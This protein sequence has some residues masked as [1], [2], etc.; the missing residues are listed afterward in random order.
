MKRET[1]SLLTEHLG[2]DQVVSD[3]AL[4]KQYAADW[5]AVSP[6]TPPVV[7]R[8]RNTNDV[9]T[10]MR[11][12]NEHHLNV[13]LQGGLTGLSGGAVP[14]DDEIVLSLERLNTIVDVDP[15]SMTMRV[16]AG[17]TLQAVQD[18]ADDAGLQFALDLGARGSC[19]IGG[20]AA[21][22]A[23]G[24]RVI[25]YGMMRDL[26]LGLEAVLANGDRVGGLNAMI[27]NNAGYDL[28]QLFIGSE[29][30]LGVITELVLRLQP[31]AQSE[32]VALCGAQSLDKLLKLLVLLKK[33]SEGRLSAFEVMWADFFDRATKFQGRAA[34]PLSDDY[35]I[36]ALVEF[37]GRDAA[38]LSLLTETIL[39]KALDSGLIDDVIIGQSKSQNQELWGIR[40]AIGDLLGELKP[41]IAFDISMPQSV[42][43]QFVDRMRAMLDRDFKKS[44]LLTFGHLGDGNLHLTVQ[45][46]D[47]TRLHEI[48][49]RILSIAGEY[50]ASISGE[51]GIGIIKKPFLKYSRSP[52]EIELMRV[53]KHAL[54]P[55]GI[56]NRGRIFDVATH[57]QTLD[58]AAE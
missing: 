22:N 17:A 35:P 49:D 7:V 58:Q 15:T 50:G 47:E 34:K 44:Q 43:G 5:S 41:F 6:R 55:N 52:A 16:Q 12:C 14:R 20:T 48:E 10:L 29:G 32:V 57:N 42:M 36:Y 13:V 54:D 3:P 37:Q 46:P 31:R 28:K 8:P 24:N 2:E 1:L 26:T 19:T 33:E 18:A 9:S 11:L 45:Y 23:G 27:K 21:T 40:D 4:L 56:L 38:D 51:H 39:G 53:L 30:T 25:K